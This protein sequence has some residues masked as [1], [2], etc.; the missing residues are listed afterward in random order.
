M[1]WQIHFFELNCVVREIRSERIDPVR[2][3]DAGQIFA[4]YCCVEH[5]ACFH[6][7]VCEICSAPFC[8]GQPR[9]LKR[10]GKNREVSEVK[11]CAERKALLASAANQP[12]CQSQAEV[13]LWRDNFHWRKQNLMEAAMQLQ[14]QSKRS[15][16]IFWC[17]LAQFWFSCKSLRCCQTVCSRTECHVIVRTYITLKTQTLWWGFQLTSLPLKLEKMCVY[18]FHAQLKEAF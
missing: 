9:K 17:W 13:S 15:T 16:H 6:V 1:H 2:M 14:M 5:R 8:V 3:F 7:S 18:V 12:R 10:L 11:S 4:A